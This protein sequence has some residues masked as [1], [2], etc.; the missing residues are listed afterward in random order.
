M[1]CPVAVTTLP[2]G[3]Y[4]P[5]GIKSLGTG[6]NKGEG[7]MPKAGPVLCPYVL[8]HTQPWM[9]LVELIHIKQS[10]NLLS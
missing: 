4:W 6:W 9:G 3:S 7:G 10:H 2:K 5:E 1:C 8:G